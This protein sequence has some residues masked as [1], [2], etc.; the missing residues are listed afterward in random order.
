MISP[1]IAPAIEIP[2]RLPSRT[3]RLDGGIS[4]ATPPVPRIGPMAMER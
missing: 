1:G 2:D 3:A 4:M